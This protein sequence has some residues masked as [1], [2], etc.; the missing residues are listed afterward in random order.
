MKRRELESF[1]SQLSGFEAPKIHLE[2]YV[3]DAT[4]ASDVLF[5]ASQEFDDI[6]DKLVVDLGAGAGALSAAAT[7]V[8]AVKTPNKGQSLLFDQKSKRP[9]YYQNLKIIYYLKPRNIANHCQLL[10]ANI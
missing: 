9:R 1:L 2:Q 7:Y 6:Q 5:T 3:T 4:I 8:S 10:K